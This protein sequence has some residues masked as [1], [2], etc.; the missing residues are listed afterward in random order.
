MRIQ[1]LFDKESVARNLHIG[2]GVSFLV[3]WKI[4][5]DTGENG[6]WLL[7]NIR[8]LKV[9][10]EKISAVVISHDHWDHTEGLWELLRNK[11]GFKVYGCPNF[12]RGFKKKVERLKG[13]LIEAQRI[14]RIAKG[15]FVTG[16]IEGNFKGE[17]LAEQAL[18]IKTNKGLTIVTGCSHPG[19]IK[20]I[21]R[22]EKGFPDK[23]IHLL[24]GGFHMIDKSRREVEFIAKKI[25]E[26]GIEK[27]G[28]THCTGNEA[29]LIFKEIYK[30]S[31][32]PIKT[33]SIFEV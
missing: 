29:Q 4:L 21:K 1:V 10:I 28:P 30:E 3:N 15:I 26:M 13:K 16:E 7:E 8:N 5:F 17:Y 9:D 27:I 19:V 2:W 25:K 18:I 31:Y 32:V 24:F 23:K 6:Y 20:I 33:G 22:V 14:T 11:E 12:G